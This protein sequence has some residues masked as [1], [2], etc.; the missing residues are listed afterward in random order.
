[1][2]SLSAQG[3]ARSGSAC[4]AD[5]GIMQSI[6]SPAARR[7]SVEEGEKRG[8][9][10][11][12]LKMDWTKPPTTGWPMGIE[13]SILPGNNVDSLA[14]RRAVGVGTIAK[15]RLG[16]DRQEERADSGPHRTA[17]NY[18]DAIEQHFAVALAKLSPSSH[19]F[20]MRA[21]DHDESMITEELGALGS[22]AT[23]TKR[24]H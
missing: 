8:G 22:I 5:V 24:P 7:S 17:A 12:G 15:R 11:G 6:F 13:C 9:R 18:N 14:V 20:E 2:V 1:M 23:N 3:V 4:Y 16:R 10:D 21:A 19:E